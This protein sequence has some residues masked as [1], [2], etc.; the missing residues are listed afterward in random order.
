MRETEDRGRLRQKRILTENDTEKE[1]MDKREMN[2]A[3]KKMVQRRKRWI[4]GR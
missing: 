4:K 3:G 1:E 2:K